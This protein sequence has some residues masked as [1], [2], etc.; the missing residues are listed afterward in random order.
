MNELELYCVNA[1]GKDGKSYKDLYLVW[2]HNE[3]TFDVRIRPNFMREADMK[4]L[5]GRAVKCET[6]EQFLSCIGK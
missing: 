4:C 2:Q 6:R 1:T 3:K 5:I